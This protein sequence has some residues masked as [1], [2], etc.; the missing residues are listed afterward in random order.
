MD[1]AE[2]KRIIESLTTIENNR[3]YW[4]V[5]TQGGNY[6]NTFLKNSYIAIGYDDISLSI[7]KK[8]FENVNGKKSL[9][10][11][12]KSKYVEELRPNYIGN[13]LIDFSYNLRKGDI[14]IIPSEASNYISIGE[15]EETPIYEIENK[16]SDDDCPFL[17]R[18]KIRWVKQNIKF[19]SIDSKLVNLKYSRRTITRIDEEMSSFIDRLLFPIYIKGDNAH[20]TLNVTKKENLPAYSL[21]STWT[22]LLDLTE[23]FGNEQKLD[24]DK[25]DIDLKINVQSPGTIE[26]ITYS[27]VG[28]VTLSLFVVALIGADF[29]SKT[30]PF[31]F[32][33]KSEG[34]IKKFQIFLI[35]KKIVLLRIS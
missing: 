4:F 10:D 8:A 32:S 11:V 23:E 24:I 22:Q 35:E 20:L 6:Y 13:Q 1:T 30:R 14:V 3:Q 15:I 5:R 29:E 31:R 21:F 34:L 2:V 16:L 17:K 27:V 33:F 25:N 28:I 18:K 19:E 7:I 26:F 9:S 12:I